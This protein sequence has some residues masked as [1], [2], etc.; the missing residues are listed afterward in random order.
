M[1]KTEPRKIINVIH[2]LDGVFSELTRKDFDGWTL[3]ECNAIKGALTELGNKASIVYIGCM[4]ETEMA[5]LER[6][7]RDEHA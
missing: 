2:L 5:E 4:T 7:G 6:E 1:V 3:E